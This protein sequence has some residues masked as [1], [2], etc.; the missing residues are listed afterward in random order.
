MG[1]P[2]MVSS[3]TAFMCLNG[4]HPCV[5]FMDVIM[6]DIPIMVGTWKCQTQAQRGQVIYSSFV[7]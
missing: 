7:L 5:D 1:I 6:G 3:N 2:P 4:T